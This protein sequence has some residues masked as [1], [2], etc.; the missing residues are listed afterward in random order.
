[1]D[2]CRI[3][4]RT[5]VYQWGGAKFASPQ[6]CPPEPP[7]A[8]NRARKYHKTFTGSQMKGVKQLENNMT[9]I[10]Q[11]FQLNIELANIKGRVYDIPYIGYGT[12][13]TAAL[14]IGTWFHTHRAHFAQR[15]I[16]DVC[17]VL[18]TIQAQSAEDPVTMIESADADDTM[19]IIESWVHLTRIYRLCLREA[20]WLKEMALDVSEPTFVVYPPVLL[21]K[22]ETIVI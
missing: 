2:A 21:L 11:E 1:M 15:E 22:I 9:Q 20:R 6:M 4:V 5:P 12:R 13:H 19:N 16:Q 10:C 14:A 7:H 8:A 18:F 17:D 3:L